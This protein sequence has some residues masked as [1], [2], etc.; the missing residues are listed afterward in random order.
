MKRMLQSSIL[1]L[2]VSIALPALAADKPPQKD[3]K[4]QKQSEAPV[5]EAPRQNRQEL[6]HL[7]NPVPGKD[8]KGGDPA[9]KAGKYADSADRLSTAVGYFPN[10]PRASLLLVNAH[11]AIG[12]FDLAAEELKRALMLKGALDAEVDELKD[13]WRDYALL[14]TSVAVLG[15]QIESSH[16]SH[17]ILLYGFYYAITGYREHAAAILRHVPDETDAAAGDVILRS[18]LPERPW[19][20]LPSPARPE[21]RPKRKSGKSES[22]LDSENVKRR[23]TIGFGLGGDIISGQIRYSNHSRLEGYGSARFYVGFLVVDKLVVDVNFSWQ[24]L[25]GDMMVPGIGYGKDIGL[26]LYTFGFDIVYHFIRKP[27]EPG[28]DPSIRIG[29]SFLDMQTDNW[30]YNG[31]YYYS[32]VMA[33]I[34]HGPLAGLSLD[35]QFAYQPVD[36]TLGL[37]VFF[38]GYLMH[39]DYGHL[40]GGGLNIQGKFGLVF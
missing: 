22:I 14:K 29:Y 21:K 34:G 40:D 27:H 39:N 38:Q 18:R 23:L 35:Y 31:G 12:S 24:Y 30:Y 11:F 3:S 2:A 25:H 16:N 8:P 26:N 17:L 7:G 20:D 19:A 4:D 10:Y 37:D 9:L 36:F 32:G 33:G 5:T 13:V 28:F 1:A 6:D 15:K